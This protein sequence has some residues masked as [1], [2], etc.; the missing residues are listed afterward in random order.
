MPGTPTLWKAET[1]VAAGSTVA[2]FSDG[3]FAVAGNYYGDLSSQFYDALGNSFGGDV[4]YDFSWPVEYMSDPRL[5]SAPDGNIYLA[6]VLEYAPNDND[7][8]GVVLTPTGVTTDLPV[9]ASS[10]DEIAGHFAPSSST[11]IVSVFTTFHHE[12]AGDYD[13]GLSIEDPTGVLPRVVMDAHGVS[14]D[15]QRNPSVSV[16]SNGNIAVAFENTVVST[17]VTTIQIS[18][19]DENGLEVAAQRVIGE[20]SSPSSPTVTSLANGNAVVAWD[21][22]YD[23]KLYFKVIGSDGSDI[24]VLRSVADAGGLDPKVV[25][26]SDGGFVMAWTSNAGT[27]IDASPDSDVAVQMFDA[28]GNRVGDQFRIDNPGDQTLSDITVMPDGRLIVVYDTETGDSTNTHDAAFVILDPRDRSISGDEGNDTIVGRLDATFINGLGGDDTLY[29]MGAKDTLTG[30]EG[31]DVL[32]GRG[33]ADTLVGG[34]GDD[35]YYVDNAKDL[36]IES[37]GEGN[38]SAI[39][40]ISYA[41][42][43]K[44]EIELLRTTANGGTAAINLTGNASFQTIIGNAGDNV[45]NDGGA[46]NNDTLIGGKGNDTYRIYNSFD[47]II[48]VS[49]SAA[50]TADRVVTSVDC[51]LDS[52]VFVEFLTTSGST[53]TSNINLAGNENA[54]TI[55]GNAG[56]NIIDGKG[57]ADALRGGSGID[58]FVF[59]TALGGTNIDKIIDFN[60]AADTIRLDDAIFTSLTSTGVLAASLF[61]DTILAPRDA[62]DLIL[63]NSNTGSLFYDADGTGSG[64]AIKFASLAPGLALTAADFVVI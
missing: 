18:V 3:R 29:G 62:D 45:L 17:G 25:G 24:T 59:S 56:S 34:I 19:F 50:G 16:L 28:S 12:G 49:G 63:Y 7:V 6:Y 43:A 44:M 14:T 41:L 40:S 23:Q 33:G 22:D 54:Q 46:G 58:F 52:G 20:T 55:I 64:A 39:A 27:E 38:D 47:T 48:E 60:V 31:N 36:I 21:D 35:V 10:D 57:G 51:A 32:N 9:R 53:G 42:G 30:G 15:W 2:S 8:F 4:L 13:V 11:R 61:K 1:I 37:G 26:T 5:T